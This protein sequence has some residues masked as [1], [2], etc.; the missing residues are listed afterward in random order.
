MD[1]SLPLHP[2]VTAFSQPDAIKAAQTDIDHEIQRLSCRVC[3][4]KSRRNSL[5]SVS[6]LPPE[7]LSEVFLVFAEQLQAQERFKVNFKWITVSHVCRLW[8]D[9][10]LQHG[11]L[12]GTI[13]MTRPDRTRVFV[14]RSKGAP[15]AIRESFPGSLAELPLPL[16]DPSYRYRELHL[17]AKEGQL[18]PNIVQVL[19]S[20]IHAPVLESLVLEVSDSYPEYTLPPTI[21]NYK[22]PALT[23]LQLQNVRFGWPT[24]LFPSLTHLSIHHCGNTNPP[25]PSVSQVLTTLRN[26]P[27]L[28]H[29]RLADQ[30]L[31]EQPLPFN[32]PSTEE[33]P[34]VSLPHL[35]TLQLFG[36]M[37]DCTTLV[38]YLAPSSFVNLAI[39]C[40][41]VENVSGI[42]TLMDFVKVNFSRN[43]TINNSSLLS[44]RLDAG[45]GELSVNVD[46]ISGRKTKR[47]V[48]LAMYSRVTEFF[49][50]R[51]STI[52]PIIFD[53]IPAAATRRLDVRSKYSISSEAWTSILNRMSEVRVLDACFDGAVNVS[54]V[55]GSPIANTPSFMGKQL[56]SLTFSGVSF[57]YKTYQRLR[58]HE[59]LL[60]SLQK[61]SDGDHRIQNLNFHSC[62]DFGATVPPQFRKVAQKVRWDQESEEDSMVLLSE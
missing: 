49:E 40:T 46:V 47:L 10:A 48:S 61:R 19:N 35:E 36:T 45:A 53:S 56:K 18:G 42:R 2:T 16:A 23:R 34:S 15:L 26:M 33:L 31:F 11:C 60:E 55:L 43:G 54:H 17:R 58:F 30:T 13:D 32:D 41:S 62:S 44:A 3:S 27:R 28:E 8:R 29:L 38:S 5:C 9:I 52:C 12:W 1:Q 51:V 20:P 6:R 7:V 25:G 21:F 59:V 22:A 14:D 37:Y 39:H 50:S 57:K 4:L 24:S